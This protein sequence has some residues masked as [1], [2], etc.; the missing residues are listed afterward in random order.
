MR[1]TD[2]RS[3]GRSALDALKGSK[4]AILSN[5]SPRMLEAAVCHKGLESYFA[6]IISVDQVMT[7]KP[8]SR[9][10]ARGPEIPKLPAAGILFVS[11]SLWDAA[12]AKA[13]G[14]PVFWCS[15][16]RAE[17]EESGVASDSTVSRRDGV[18]QTLPGYLRRSGVAHTQRNRSPGELHQK[19]SSI[20]VTS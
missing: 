11:Y 15:R 7:Y 19:I 14:Y 8:S 6:A 16:S 4:L 1:L 18:A 3:E 17:M 13:F 9:V 12:G 20:S 2:R 5:G 10:Y